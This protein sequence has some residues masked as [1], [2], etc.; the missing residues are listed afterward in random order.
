MDMQSI[1]FGSSSQAAG[2][3]EGRFKFT[4]LALGKD[5]TC[6][7]DDGGET[8][9]IGNLQIAET[10]AVAVA[11][12]PAG[13]HVCTISSAGLPADSSQPHNAHHR[14]ISCAQCRSLPADTV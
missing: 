6:A 13:K 7:V 8:E 2:A 5:T 12:G 3:E 1:A 10:D 11:V 14:P 9:C 4:A